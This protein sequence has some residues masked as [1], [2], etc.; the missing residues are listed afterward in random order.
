KAS[1]N[2]L[3]RI[4]MAAVMFLLA[5]VFGLWG[6][7]DIFTGFGRSTLAK[8]GNTE[9]GI[10][11][12]Q[13]V[14]RD[15]LNQ[16]SHDF[17]KPISPQEA[18]A[19]GLDRQVLGEMIAQSAM[20][21]RARQIGLGIPDT[22]IARHITTDPNLQTINGQFDRNKFEQ[23]LRNM[24]MT[25]QRFV[26][27]QR[28]TALRRQVI[29]SM[30][31]DLS[32]PKAWLDAINQFQNELRSVNYVVLGPEQAGVIPQ[33]T[34]EEL[35]KYFDERK[36][37]F[38]APE[39]RKIDVVAVTPTELAKWMEI[40]D[41]DIKSTYQKEISRFTTPERRHIQQ[42]IFPTMADAQ[43]AADR[44]KS[45]TSFAAIAAGR[46]L[47]EQDTDL[48]TV[49]KSTIVD[50]AEAD[51]AFALKEGEVSAPVQGRFGAILATVLK[52]EPQVTKS[53][54]DV[55]TQIRGD[56]A[57][58]RA[59]AQVQDLHDKI[60]DDRAGGATLEQAMEKLKL[61]IVTVNVDRSGH[62]PDGKPVTNIPHAADIVNAGYASDVGVDND[63][64]DADGGY[65][66]YAVTDI[67]KAH[68]RNLDEVRAQVT[69][70]WRDDE[71]AARLKTKAE[72]ILGKLK[73]G[74]A[75]DAVATANKL[76]I[77]AATD[78]KRGGSSGAITPRM[79]EAIFSTAKDAYGD[80][81]GDVPT[82]WVVFRVTD[83]KTPSLDPN[84]A[85]AKTVL[86]TVQRQ[87]A[88]DVIG[89]YMAWL[90]PYLGVKI[91][92]AAL[93]QAMGNLGNGP[94]DSN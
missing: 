16:M 75:F 29:D 81:V 28:Q 50:P 58:D 87:M 45:G 15:R 83:I 82:Q 84:S 89:Q 86:Q 12:F 55:S 46:G 72:E 41:D 66:W 47:K 54:T 3:G 51:A 38:R 32:P 64:I 6:I 77:E 80:S 92:T 13:Q 60:E 30:T 85:G 69:Q 24:G 94:L 44:I 65:V 42:I 90:E 76:K 67:A 48:G 5:G 56:I 53:L 73:G 62:D 34:D 31:G 27:E 71:I 26:A 21:Q 23:I 10:P 74:E 4:V 14:Y 43:A 8:I 68:D 2:W 11:E 37:M 88:D 7:N 59:K 39:Y 17:G 20:D 49:A 1:E 93:A 57:L 36:I 52:I 19:L 9:I 79:T 18:T 40:S 91:N 35:S 78:L 22:E 25:E 63:P 33:P 70:R 61:P